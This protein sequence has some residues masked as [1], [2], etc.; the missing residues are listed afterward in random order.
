MSPLPDIR[1]YHSVVTIENVGEY[2]IGGTGSTNAKTTSEFLPANSLQW[3]GGPGLPSDVSTSTSR[4]CAVPVSNTSFIYINNGVI[5]EY[6]T[7]NPTSNAGWMDAT[8]WPV[9]SSRTNQACARINNYVLISGG[10]SNGGR[11]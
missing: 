2:A 9:L 1:A 11:L 4:G 8:R 10:D 3:K 6:E 5:R 7:S